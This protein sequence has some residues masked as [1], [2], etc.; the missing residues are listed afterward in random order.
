MN[1]DLLNFAL[2]AMTELQASSPYREGN[3]RRAITLVNIEGGQNYVDII[4]AVDY[5]SYVNEGKPKGSKNERV[6]KGWI[7][8]TME[9]HI[10]AYN[11]NVQVEQ[12]FNF[13]VDVLV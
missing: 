12:G 3:M 2:S 5:A 11:S 4:I 13:D 6:N 1:N 10:R 9:R 7:E 8:K